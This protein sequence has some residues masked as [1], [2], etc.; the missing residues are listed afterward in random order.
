MIWCFLVG[1]EAIRFQPVFLH[2]V[3]QNALGGLQQA[4]RPARATEITSI[5]NGTV[6]PAGH[7]VRAKRI[8]IVTPFYNE[9]GVVAIYFERLASVNGSLATSVAPRAAAAANQRRQRRQRSLTGDYLCKYF[10]TASVREL[11][12]SFR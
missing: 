6:D 2:L 12:C 4:G 5:M 10:T 1:L 9:A 11:T 3:V 8:S 7:Q